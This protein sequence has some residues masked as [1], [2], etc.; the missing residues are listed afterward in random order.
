MYPSFW[1]KKG[2][3]NSSNLIIPDF[4]KWDLPSSIPGG[5]IPVARL[6]VP[7]NSL[8]ALERSCRVGF[9][10][11]GVTVKMDVEFKLKYQWCLVMRFQYYMCVYCIYLYVWVCVCISKCDYVCVCVKITYTDWDVVRRDMFR[12][13]VSPKSNIP[14]LLKVGHAKQKYIYHHITLQSIYRLHIRLYIT[15]C[16]TLYIICYVMWK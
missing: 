5:W 9:V 6:G 10:G 3:E 15:L 14:A 13:S 7:N 12:G 1:W 8:D 11:L 2:V 16:S 4:N